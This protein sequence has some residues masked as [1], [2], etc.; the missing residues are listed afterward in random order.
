MGQTDE[1][2]TRAPRF[3]SGRV[4]SSWDARKSIVV[5]I[6][7]LL[8]WILYLR[9]NDSVAALEPASYFRYFRYFPQPL[10]RPQVIAPTLNYSTALCPA[11]SRS[12]ECLRLWE[13]EAGSA[14]ASEAAWSASTKP[15]IRIQSGPGWVR[16]QV[17]RGRHDCPQSRCVWVPEEGGDGEA[18]T[19]AIPPL[20]SATSAGRFTARSLVSMEACTVY[21]D[22]CNGTVLEA[23]G[24]THVLTPERLIGGEAAVGR[25]PLTYSNGDFDIYRSPPVPTAMKKRAV[26]AI[27]SNCDNTDSGRGAVLKGLMD[28]GLEVHSFGVCLHNAEL[29]TQAPECAHLPRET[30]FL[31]RQKLCILRSYR[32]TVAFESRRVPG[33]ATEKLYQPLMVG[34]V[35]IYLGAPD[36]RQVLPHPDAAILADDFASP[37]LL[38]RQLAVLMADDAA[39]EKHLTWRSGMFSVGFRDALRD[40][41]NNMQCKICDHAVMASGLQLCETWTMTEMPDDELSIFVLGFTYFPEEHKIVLLTFME[42]FDYYTGPGRVQALP[43]PKGKELKLSL[44]HSPNAEAVPCTMM[45]QADVNL[46]TCPAPKPFLPASA[47]M[48]ALTAVRNQTVDI[49]IKLC[50]ARRFVGDSAT[51]RVGICVATVYDYKGGLTLRHLV[52]FAEYHR[53]LGV[54]VIK[55]YMRTNV[56][57]K[58]AAPLEALYGDSVQAVDISVVSRDPENAARNN[59]YYDQEVALNHCLV[60]MRG[61]ADWVGFFDFDE[62][63]YTADHAPI[64]DV[65]ERLAATTS[66]EVSCINIG[67]DEI[68]TPAVRPPGTWQGTIYETFVHPVHAELQSITAPKTSRKMFCKP[69]WASSVMNHMGY[70]ARGTDVWPETAVAHFRHYRNMVNDRTGKDVY[71][72]ASGVTRPVDMTFAARVQSAVEQ[73]LQRIS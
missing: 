63:F 53:V 18:W 55:M 51:P 61:E 28:A 73:S 17:R 52:D 12:C 39:Y 65:L 9:I 33:Y 60:R 14:C 4:A 7:V 26:A 58:Y 54:D 24:Y 72:M 62:Y 69:M 16:E 35:P 13:R 48:L 46:I 3:S 57:A 10:K 25:I 66:E 22:S 19:S 8:I 30:P 15:L 5:A 40:Q 42:G 31:D 29:H 2:R 44:R 56:Y 41:Y 32:F 38:A 45:E 34:S 27:I 43:T 37:D 6:A 20:Q 36:V 23:L 68:V 59:G 70:R 47:N 50:P 1:L 11:M 71:P 21:P 67:R 64:V 49:N